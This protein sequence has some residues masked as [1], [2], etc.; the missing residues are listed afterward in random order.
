MIVSCIS[1]VCA[2]FK[3]LPHTSQHLPRWK[4][5]LEGGLPRTHDGI[6]HFLCL[7]KVQGAAAHL[8]TFVQVENSIG[9][10]PPRKHDG[11]MHHLC[12]YKVQ[13]ADPACWQCSFLMGPRVPVP[14]CFFMG[15]L[16]FFFSGRF[17]CKTLTPAP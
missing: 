5:A 13:G 4:S 7:H 11:I 12:F 17:T 8:L 16:T 2:K 15:S 6:M 3:V 1:F 10:W 9:R 14:G